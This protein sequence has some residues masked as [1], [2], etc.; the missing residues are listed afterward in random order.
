MMSSQQFILSWRLALYLVCVDIHLRA[1][2]FN[3]TKCPTL[4]CSTLLRGRWTRVITTAAWRKRG[5]FFFFSLGVIPHCCRNVRLEESCSCCCGFT[6]P[7]VF[8]LRLHLSPSIDGGSLRK[9]SRVMKGLEL[10]HYLWKKHTASLNPRC[11]VKRCCGRRLSDFH[12][13]CCQCVWQAC[14]WYRW[15]RAEPMS[16]HSF[17]LSDCMNCHWHAAVWISGAET[18]QAETLLSRKKSHSCWQSDEVFL[19]EQ[20]PIETVRT[21]N[22]MSPS[23]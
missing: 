20:M 9:L 7:S 19:N 2:T 21:E 11:H 10:Q 4:C 1:S 14:V 6:S 12:Q 8:L 15:M 16:L 13:C 18:C 17:P 3:L 23:E 5:R 22:F